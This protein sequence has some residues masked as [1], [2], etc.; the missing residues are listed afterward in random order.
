MMRKGF[1]IVELLVAIFI[2]MLGAFIILL[3]MTISATSYARSNTKLKDSF[4]NFAQI[5]SGIAGDENALETPESKVSLKD[6]LNSNIDALD[7]IE[8]WI[9]SDGSKI[10]VLKSTHF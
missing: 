7:N 1:T 5:T 3:A 10:L 4:N 8:V 2:L 6:Y 9:Y